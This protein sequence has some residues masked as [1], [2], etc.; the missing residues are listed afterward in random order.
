MPALDARLHFSQGAGSVS[1]LH[2]QGSRDVCDHLAFGLRG[3]SPEDPKE[4]EQNW[5]KGLRCRLLISSII[6]HREES[7]TAMI[8]MIP[9]RKNANMV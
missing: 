1:E 9:P 7:G 4:R 5:R 6:R 8:S 2:V 3:R